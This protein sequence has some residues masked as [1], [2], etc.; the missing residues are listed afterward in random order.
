MVTQVPEKLREKEEG[1]AIWRL[2]AARSYTPSWE[3]QKEEVVL[4]LLRAWRH[5]IEPETTEDLSDGH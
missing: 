2:A 3:K 5:L 1:E 4:P